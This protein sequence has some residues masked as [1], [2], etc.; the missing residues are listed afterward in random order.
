MDGLIYFGFALLGLSVGSFLNLCIDRLPRGGSIVSPPSHCDNCG[1]RLRPL[2]LVP[3]L[4]YLLLRGR[5]RYCGAGIPIRVLIVEL[6]S[7]TLYAL[8]AWH[9]DLNLEL[10]VALIFT[11][12]FLVIFFIDLEHGLILNAVVFPAIAIA[13]VFSFFRSGYAEIWP[14]LGPGFVLSA[15]LGGA[16]GFTILLLP[17]IISRGGMGAGDVKLAGLIGLVNGF[18]LVLVA[19]FTGIVAG[20]AVAISLLLSRVVGRTDAIPFGPFLAVGAVVSIVWGERVVDWY[21]TS[22]TGL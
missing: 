18:P 17:Y 14:D 4:S 9:F 5:C 10:A 20:G 7:G 2:E 8:M 11:S 16:V 6:A 1:R 3:V 19:M 12:V 22:F 15:M 21:Q 13:F